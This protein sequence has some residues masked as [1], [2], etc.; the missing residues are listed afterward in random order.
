[1][2][3]YINRLAPRSPVCLLEN[4]VDDQHMPASLSWTSRVQ[5]KPSALKQHKFV[6]LYDIQ[7]PEDG[8][9]VILRNVMPQEWENWTFFICIKLTVA[10]F[11]KKFPAFNET[12]LVVFKG[13]D[14]W[15][16]SS[17]RRT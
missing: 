14:S 17:T 2:S 6:Y 4:L 10:L 9:R 5:A 3:Y 1:M 11:V 16:L 13:S 8:D 15:T 12:Y 7:S